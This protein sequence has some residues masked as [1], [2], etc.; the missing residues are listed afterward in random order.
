MKIVATKHEPVV[1]IPLVVGI[2]P[3]VVQPGPVLVPF[4]VEE[5]RVAVRIRLCEKRHPTTAP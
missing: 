5:V 3:I 1:R 2:V 4:H